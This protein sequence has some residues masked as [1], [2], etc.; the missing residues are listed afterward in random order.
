M[1]SLIRKEKITCENCGTQTT[2]NNIV[3]HKK[4][5]SAGTL[6]CP[7]CPNF[8]KLSQ[9]DLIY[10]V[11]K[12]HSAA[13]P[14]KTFKCNLCHA[15]FLGFFALRRHKNNQHGTKIGFGAT[16]IGVEDIVGDV[17]DQ[18]SREELQSCKHFLVDSEIQKGRHSV[19]NLLSKTLQL[20][21]SKKNWIA[22]WID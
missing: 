13:G 2:R 3:R 15:E 8:S 18:S 21:L 17:D 4:R 20:R 5:C 16:N 1:P 9:D 11:A 12:Q 19:F 7:Q 10:H 22:F 14:S 6:Y